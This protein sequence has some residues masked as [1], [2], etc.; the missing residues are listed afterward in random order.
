MLQHIRQTNDNNSKKRNEKRILI[1]K[2]NAKCLFI[3]ID[4]VYG[5]NHFIQFDATAWTATIWHRGTWSFSLSYKS[6]L[7]W[8]L[9]IIH[10]RKYSY[11]DNDA[12]RIFVI[13]FTCASNQHC[14]QRNF[15]TAQFTL[16]FNAFQW[17][18][19]FYRV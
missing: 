4:T 18:V 17:Q 12:E 7:P 3:I 13:I 5:C 14:A 11:W 10:E 15:H 9:F 16:P 6:T 8:P 1:I 19:V 2:L